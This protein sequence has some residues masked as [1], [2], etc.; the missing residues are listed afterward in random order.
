[1]AHLINFTS[2]TAFTLPNQSFLEREVSGAD[3]GVNSDTLDFKN[4]ESGSALPEPGEKTDQTTASTS[5]EASGTALETLNKEQQQQVAELV[6]RDREV[7]NHEAA[8]ANVGGRF[9]GSPSFTF[10]RGPDGK[11]YAIAGEVPI[12]VAPV[13][14]DPQATI[15]KA[16]IV[17]RAA[18]AP[19]NPSAQD[20]AVAAE[21]LALESEARAELLA[22]RVEQN[23]EAVSTQQAD[24]NESLANNFSSF[25]SDSNGEN[26]FQQ[27]S[28][29]AS[30][31]DAIEASINPNDNGLEPVIDLL[32]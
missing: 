8:H 7:R 11:S 24:A 12:D 21:A 29:F 2:N 1:M 9:A 4:A 30:L 28:A 20:R 14:N 26:G 22:S 5:V 10:Q 17:R 18:L 6:A 25:D 27:S 13:P 32:V 19:A 3:S 15:Q 31:L 16:Q 23:N